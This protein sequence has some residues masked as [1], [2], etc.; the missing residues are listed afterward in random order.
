MQVL[1]LQGVN[2][3]VWREMKKKEDEGRKKRG[4]IHIFIYMDSP[5]FIFA[6]TMELQ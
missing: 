6:P 4:E 2:S 5:M 3:I 1:V